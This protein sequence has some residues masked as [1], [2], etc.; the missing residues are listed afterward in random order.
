MRL[1]PTF[2]SKTAE[3]KAG[4]SLPNICCPKAT[5]MCKIDILDRIHKTL[6]SL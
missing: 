5:D 2:A 6:F 3:L 4:F 1:T